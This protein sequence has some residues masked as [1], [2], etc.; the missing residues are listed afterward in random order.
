MPAESLADPS[1]HLQNLK[2]EISRLTQQQENALRMA[3]YV[4]M[5]EKEAAEYDRRHSSINALIQ[6]LR[7]LIE[8]P[9]PQA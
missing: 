3:V 9:E 5:T 2:Q 7:S 6:Q 4:G 8:K 1:R